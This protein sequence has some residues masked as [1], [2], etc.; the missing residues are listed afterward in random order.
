VVENVG[1]LTAES[2]QVE[3][4]IQGNPAT[5]ALGSSILQMGT[6]AAGTQATAPFTFLIDMAFATCGDPIVFDVDSLSW[7]GGANP[8][9]PG[10]YTARTGGVVDDVFDDFEDPSTWSGIGDPT[11]TTDTWVVTTGPGPHSGG[12]WIRAAGGSQGQPSGSTGFFAV[13][14]SDEPGSGSTTSSILW[15]PVIDMSAVDTGTVSLEFDAYFNSIQDDEYA[16]VDVYDGSNWQNL[17][18]WTDTDV[19]GHQVLDVTA[20]ALG[21]PDFRVRFSYQDATWDWW[22]AIDN[23]LIDIEGYVGECDNT[24][25]CG[26]VGLIFANGFESGTVGAWTRAVP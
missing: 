12:E 24:V 3:L 14:D 10:V 21:N 26:S 17:I 2:T 7:S 8:G 19:N 18:H 15:S 6:V 11:T 16:D 1:N 5:V 23:Y 9:V 13:S 25:N 4:S 22:F 20:Y